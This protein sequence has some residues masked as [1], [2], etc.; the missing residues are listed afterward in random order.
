M[1]NS[2]YVEV[3]HIADLAIRVWGKDFKTIFTRAAEGLYAVM[4]IKFDA[5]SQNDREFILEKHT[6]DPENLL[7][8]F[9]NEL[10][11]LGENDHI[12]LDSIHFVEKRDVVVVKART[13]RIQ[14]IEREV[15]AVTY[16]ELEIAESDQG[17]E[18][19]I[20]FDI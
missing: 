3:D 8:D 5:T 16:H 1:N 11:Y 17:L 7:V 13:H 4:R 9:L 20:T 14:T 6:Q 19:T 12:Y 2:G 10:L 15:K 18:T